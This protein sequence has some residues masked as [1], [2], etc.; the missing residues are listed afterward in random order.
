MF[1][2]AFS[3]F[4]VK[5]TKEAKDFY[6]N[7]LGLEVEDNKEEEGTLTLYLPDGAKVFIYPK[8]NHEPA[9]YTVLKPMKKGYLEVQQPE[10]G[11]LHGL[12]I[13]PEISSQFFRINN[14]LV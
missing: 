7:I 6:S 1:K 11:R 12:K 10:N 9:T 3:G 13:P 2:R 8:E 5:D 4:S 14:N